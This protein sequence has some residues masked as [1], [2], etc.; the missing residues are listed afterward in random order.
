MIFDK[1]DFNKILSAERYLFEASMDLSRMLPVMTDLD[2]A[3]DN[4][5]SVEYQALSAILAVKEVK[6]V[7]GVQR[8]EN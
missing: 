6:A 7:L 4:L 1:D 2:E 5:E 8:D 3:I